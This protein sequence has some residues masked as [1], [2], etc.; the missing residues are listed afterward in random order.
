M[1][2]SDSIVLGRAGISE[3]AVECAH[4]RRPGA[5]LPI[6]LLTGPAGSG[7]T[8]ML[9]ELRR[10]VQHLPHAFVDTGSG[11]HG[12]ALDVLTA[13]VFQLSLGHRKIGRLR[14]PRFLLGQLVGQLPL[15]RSPEADRARVRGLLESIKRFRRLPEEIREISA[16]LI[17][18]A[19]PIPDGSSDLALGGIEAALKLW[20]AP[21][22]IWWASGHQ[23]AVDALL[24]L[25]H[26]LTVGT[27]DERREAEDRLCRAFVADLLAAYNN[28]LRGPDR[29]V[30]SVL[31]LDNAHT[32]PGHKV[33][34][35]LAR[36]R[37]YEPEP[38][39]L[40]V[41]AATG[42]LLP[43]RMHTSDPVPPERIDLGAWR[44][45]RTNDHWRRWFLPV[46]LRDLTDDEVTHWARQH[47][48]YGGPIPLFA[49]RLTHGHPQGT[50]AVLPM[51]RGKL[52][53]SVLDDPGEDAT[54]GAELLDT[55]LADIP[56]GFHAPL[57]RC[58]AARDLVPA[59][60]R[61]ALGEEAELA[62]R[63]RQLVTERLWLTGGALHPWLRRLLLLRLEDDWS[64]VHLRLRTLY[65]EQ[66]DLAGQHYHDLALE[67][68]ESAVRGLDAA[69]T[70]TD[71]DGDPAGPAAW[72]KLLHAVT[73]A[74]NK[75]PRRGEA[76]ARRL[77]SWADAEQPRVRALARLT[78]ELWIAADPLGDPEGL[79]YRSI[80]TRFA[81]LGSLLPSCSDEFFAKA[82][83][84]RRRARDYE[85]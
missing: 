27:P 8:V 43:Q 16:R 15:G 78:T 84:Y 80:A 75:L 24:E 59:T 31:L 41:F 54:L 64:I 37:T 42:R 77:L 65:A 61:A 66:K 29:T 62:D 79:L 36:V 20:R 30:S 70:G 47:Q 74:P 67:D 18:I 56:P 85:F 63:L 45:Q 21:G 23:P 57:A 11:R 52:R 51:V 12:S 83:E 58:A 4:W 19:A 6:V 2:A 38:L 60:M 26:H 82:E 22:Q 32:T 53:R 73:A 10:V 17:D 7:K 72:L 50:D 14:F 33:L 9:R 81:E 69:L 13:A 44:R 35:L 1:V 28:Q 55:L 68:T 39:P 34:E 49:H 71:P 48:V 3:L 5:D 25:H 76:S 40:L 46:Q